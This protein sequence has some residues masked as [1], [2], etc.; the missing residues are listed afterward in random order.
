MRSRDLSRKLQSSCHPVPIQR[1]KWQ[2]HWRHLSFE[3]KLIG[4]EVGKSITGLPFAPLFLFLTL[5]YPPMKSVPVCWLKPWRAE[6]CW[7]F[8][9][10]D[11]T[12]GFKADW[13]FALITLV[14]LKCLMSFKQVLKPSVKKLITWQEM[15]ITTSLLTFAPV[16]LLCIVSKSW[17]LSPVI[18]FY[19]YGM[20]VHGRQRFSN[21]YFHDMGLSTLCGTPDRWKKCQ[22]CCS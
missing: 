11:R 9:V 21:V 16:G 6:S 2:S 22:Q 1:C 7:H 8:K 17:N 14:Y 18:W 19:W 12:F 13:Q 10:W 15:S 3:R 4:M 20:L 5:C